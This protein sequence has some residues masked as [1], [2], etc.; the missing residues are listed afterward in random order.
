M[1]ARQG[2][3]HI[4]AR[5]HFGPHRPVPAEDL[6]EE[7]ERPAGHAQGEHRVAGI[8][9]RAAGLLV[10]QPVGAAEDVLVAAQ[11]LFVREFGPRPGRGG[12]HGRY[13]GDARPPLDVVVRQLVEAPGTPPLPQYPLGDLP[14]HPRRG[15]F[16]QVPPHDLGDEF[17]AEI[18]HFPVARALQPHHLTPPELRHRPRHPAGAPGHGRGEGVGGDGSVPQRQPIRQTPCR[19]GEGLQPLRQNRPDLGRHLQVFCAPLEELPY[20]RAAA[21][22]P[23]F[24]QMLQHLLQEK[25]VPPD[26]AVEP[27]VQGRGQIVGAGDPH[28]HPAEA[29]PVQRLERE[30]FPPFVALGRFHDRLQVPARILSRTE[31]DARQDRVGAD[32]GPQ[33][34]EHGAA[35]AVGI[36]KIVQQQ[37]GRGV[38][39]PPHQFPGQLILELPRGETRRPLP[40]VRGTGPD[41]LVEKGGL[42]FRVQLRKDLSIGGVGRLLPDSAGAFGHVPP[43]EQRPASHLLHEPGLPCPRLPRQEK[44][45]PPP[46]FLHPAGA[47]LDPLHFALP[48]HEGG[49]GKT[50][51]RLPDRPVGADEAPDGCG[52]FQRRYRPVFRVFFEH[53][54]QEQGQGAA[55]AQAL[56]RAQ[57]HP[58]LELLLDQE[59]LVVVFEGETPA[60]QQVEQDSQGVDVGPG[61][62]PPAQQQLR[63]GAGRGEGI[64][65]IGEEPPHSV[66]QDDGASFFPLP[67][68]QDGRRPQ[69]PVHDPPA[70]QVVERRRQFGAQ[71]ERLLRG[72]PPGGRPQARPLHPLLG[73]KQ[74]ARILGDP[75]IQDGNQAR[76]PQAHQHRQRGPEGVPL[77]PGRIHR[78]QHPE[79]QIAR[80]VAKV[81]AGV[82]IPR[83]PAT[84]NPFDPVPPGDNGAVLEFSLTYAHSL[85]PGRIGSLPSKAQRVRRRRE[86]GPSQA[87]PG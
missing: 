16:R 59:P 71:G 36:V 60:D 6:P 76:M 54:A 39:Q 62:G 65:V 64:A 51:L 61:R 74:R 7:G 44:G 8:D 78:A 80:T 81:P 12:Q 83:P 13:G 30:D 35:G 24:Q 43:L 85:P 75:E 2:Q 49:A 82:D 20:P 56:D 40:R 57:V 70:V 46:A 27:V 1:L 3:L 63:S 50:T 42:P 48:P 15:P 86:T 23:L 5:A 26:G 34:V 17:V 72:Q 84:Q 58:R 28:G 4:H 10:R 47:G 29:L 52:R 25:G 21:Q 55:P 79:D 14:M 32:I 9:R 18:D 31:A 38:P 19:G 11:G 87:H 77:L 67:H 22:R 41:R 53:P 45:P 66:A 68:Q 37:E 69:I 33:V 73:Q